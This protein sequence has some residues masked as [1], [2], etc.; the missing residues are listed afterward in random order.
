MANSVKL[1]LMVLSKTAV[2]HSKIAL[3][4]ASS[5]SVK[6]LGLTIDHKLNF[7]I[8]I[9]NLWKVASAKLKGLG[10]FGKD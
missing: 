4:I 1:Q 5:K 3:K 9:N 8:H 10:R 2:N 7:D 6:L